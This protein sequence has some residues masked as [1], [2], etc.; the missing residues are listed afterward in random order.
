MVSSDL[1]RKTLS[2]DRSC[3]IT[4]DVQD[5]LA[6]AIADTE[7]VQAEIRKL[8]TAASQLAVPC[9]FT[10]QY[11]GGLGATLPQVRGPRSSRRLSRR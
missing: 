10:E 2:A 4:I 7:S 6:Q 5:R 3:L 9:V 11:P 1:P 8:L